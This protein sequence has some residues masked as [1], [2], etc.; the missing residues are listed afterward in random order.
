LLTHP[1]TDRLRELGL[2]GMAR[3][4]EELRRQPDSAGLDFEE[5]LAMLVDRERL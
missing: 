1:T 5:R 2:L 3:A 4:L